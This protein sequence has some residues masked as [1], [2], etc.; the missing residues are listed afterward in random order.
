MP[1]RMNESKKDRVGSRQV[2]LGRK[3]NSAGLLSG[4]GLE[5]VQSSR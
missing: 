3:L 1:L 4:K 2:D 5:A